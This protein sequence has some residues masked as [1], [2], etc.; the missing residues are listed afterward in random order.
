[1]SDEALLK[2]VG[3]SFH[4]AGRLAKLTDF[5]Y[6]DFPVVA[7]EHG[8]IVHDDL[9]GE[10]QYLVVCEPNP[11]SGVG[12]KAAKLNG[13]GASIQTI[14]PPAFLE[15]LLPTNDEVR[16]LLT[17]GSE[18]HRRLHAMLDVIH[19]FD[20]EWRDRV[21]FPTYDCQ[22][23][24]LQGVDLTVARR[25]LSHCCFDRANLGGVQLTEQTQTP[26]MMSVNLDGARLYAYLG[27]LEDCS[28][29][30][31]DF[32]YATLRGGA[33]G[34]DFTRA[35]LESIWF[36]KAKLR[37]CNFRESNLNESGAEEIV[38]D[39]LNFT[40][41]T[42]REAECEGASFQR[43]DFTEADLSEADL[44][45]VNF[46]QANLSGA[47]L[48]GANLV[49][50]DLSYVNVTGA[51]FTGAEMAGVNWTG[52]DLSQAIGVTVA[53]TKTI[54]VGA[55]LLE[56]SMLA[57]NSSL[58][59]FVIDI[60]T[61]T[62]MWQFEVESGGPSA[63]ARWYKAEDGRYS[64]AN[65]RNQFLTLNDAFV[66]V[67]GLLDGTL[68]P[69]TL[70]VKGSKTGVS[71]KALKTLVM[72]ALYEAFGG[73]L[74][75]AK[76]MDQ[77][78]QQKKSDLE[79]KRSELFVLLTS[80]TKAAIEE[81]NKQIETVEGLDFQA[82]QLEG[83]TLDGIAFG[84]SNFDRSNLSHA[85]L[86]GANLGNASFLDATFQSADLSHAEGALGKFD[87]ADL[88]KANLN[89]ARFSWCSL[90][91]A[92]LS[93]A[94]LTR[95]NF[96]GSYL[97]GANLSKA[98]ID[99]K[100]YKQQSWTAVSGFTRFK[101]AQFDEA[102]KFPGKRFPFGLIWK[103]KGLD[104]RQKKA[105]AA[106]KTMGSL[107]LEQFMS[108][109]GAMSL[110]KSRIG[111]AVS[112]LKKDRF[113]LFSELTDNHVIGIV[114]SQTDPDLVYSCRLGSAGDFSCCTQNLKP[115]G[116]LRGAI[117]KHLLVL[118]IGLAQRDEQ[119]AQT[120]FAWILA[121]QRHKPTL[122]KMAMS[123][124]LL[125]YKGAEAG[126]IDWRPMETIPEDYFAI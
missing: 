5:P 78:K 21:V 110:E 14:T 125:R 6:R 119:Q 11:Q 30:G 90:R 112:M 2:L 74:P 115:C 8:G 91:G 126:E 117:C 60:K 114:K 87:R 43:A 12:K 50:A 61:D 108:G 37:N 39:G 7:R 59:S 105:S 81:W 40:R 68:R 71:P 88:S 95:T 106:T 96:E 55:K 79:A 19:R 17:G 84:K 102:T 111:N 57:Q 15:M 116:G 66:R 20:Y 10:V 77:I 23:M 32:T 109:L 122:D 93:G 121:S 94:N 58:V 26:P 25:I 98:T 54:T 24:D 1:M 65:N 124:T 82:I 22:K 13:N 62:G 85:A 73:D 4:F 63:I 46:R 92:N 29:V 100:S 42:L 64:S 47:K 113:Q 76:S 97:Q 35:N 101:D 36:E 18:G 120:L 107:T 48:T 67:A 3:K 52:V 99:D 44:R 41:A 56:L 72:E 103:G 89:D 80:P 69:E 34:C 28:C 27:R 45:K 51:D 49:E 75:D 9:T 123:E 31:A 53:P 83:K 38:A 70:V 33:S 104:P 118:L 86:K 16:E